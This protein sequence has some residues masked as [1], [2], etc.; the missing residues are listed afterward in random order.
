MRTLCVL[1][2]TEAEFLGLLEDHFENRAIRFHYVRPFTPG[3]RMPAD[4]AGFDGLVLL[5]AAPYGVVSGMLLPS[6]A[7]ELRLTRDFLAR[8]LP[9]VGIGAG[10]AIL[11][12]AA[13]GGVAEAPLHVGLHEARRLRDDALHGHLPASYPMFVCMRDRPVPPDDATVL[14]E[15]ET[16]APALFGLRGNCLGFI[17]HPGLKSGMLEDLVLAFDEMPADSGA[18]LMQLRARQADLAEALS[19]IMVGLIAVT[20]LMR[21]EGAPA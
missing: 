2:H 21:A 12:V 15:D 10:A 9:V 13:G 5:G 14:A 20:G 18:A 6:L 11:C 19:G 7:A 8:G 16:G 3:A 4:A 17:G 1:Q